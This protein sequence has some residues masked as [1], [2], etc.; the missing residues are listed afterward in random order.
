MIKVV[1]IL[2][3]NEIY[4]EALTKGVWNEKKFYIAT[5]I[6]GISRQELVLSFLNSDNYR[7]PEIKKLPF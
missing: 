1:K 6:M 7:Y 5:L 2:N 3:A 4:S